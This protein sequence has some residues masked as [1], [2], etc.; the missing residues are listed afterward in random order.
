MVPHT[1]SPSTQVAQTGGLWIQVH[2]GLHKETLA[3]GP[4]FDPQRGVGGVGRVADGNTELN[5]SESGLNLL[6]TQQQ[7][8]W[9]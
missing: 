5:L 7:V 3:Q 8:E 4:G 2:P 9:L 1:Y 6:E